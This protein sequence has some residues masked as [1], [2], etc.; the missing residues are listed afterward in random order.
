MTTTSANFCYY[1]GTYSVFFCF[2]RMAWVVDYAITDDEGWDTV[3]KSRLCI[4]VDEV[5]PLN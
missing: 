2:T 5:P 3:S 1:D 4:F